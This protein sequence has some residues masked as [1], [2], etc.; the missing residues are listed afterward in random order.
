MRFFV[1]VVEDCFVVNVSADLPVRPGEGEVVA[2]VFDER[3]FDII[4]LLLT[5]A[6]A[7]F[8][9]V[10]FTRSTT[11]SFGSFMRRLCACR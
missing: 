7:F 9:A 6:E 3:A 10:L 8:S 4:G 11:T 5:C 1:A 2:E